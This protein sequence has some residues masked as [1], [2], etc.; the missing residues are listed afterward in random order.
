MDNVLWL[1]VC[2]AFGVVLHLLV[3]WLLVI[4]STFLTLVFICN[5]SVDSAYFIELL[6]G[7]N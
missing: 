4:Y 3:D 5:E 1:R 7:L 6:G 2:M